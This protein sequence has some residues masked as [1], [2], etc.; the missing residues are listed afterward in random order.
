MLRLTL[1]FVQMFGA[2]LSIAPLMKLG[3]STLSMTAVVLTSL[4]TTVSVV[5]FGSRSPRARR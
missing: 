4:C 1:G 3:V 5:L 2:G